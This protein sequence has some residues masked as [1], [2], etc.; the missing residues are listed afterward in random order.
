VEERGQLAGRQVPVFFREAQHRVLHDVERRFLVAHGE[1]RLLERALLDALQ[2]GRKLAA[3]CQGGPS[4]V[5]PPMVSKGTRAKA[6]RSLT[7]LHQAF[8]LQCLTYGPR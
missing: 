5:W 2:E 7:A 8:I 6:R 4:V 1:H 3:G